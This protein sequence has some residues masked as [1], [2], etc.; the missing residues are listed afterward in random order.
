MRIRDII[1]KQQGIHGLE[2]VT[3]LA[4][5]LAMNKEQLFINLDRQIDET[6]NMRIHQFIS[7][8]QQGKPLAY[9]TGTKEFFSEEFCVDERVLI[10]RPET[11]LLVEEAIK[12]LAKIPKADSIIDMGTGSGAVGLTV[13]RIT[14]KRVLCVDESTGAL[15]VAKSNARKLGVL[16]T[17]AF[18]CS[19]LFRAI[20]RK[21]IFD[22]VL[23]N[24]PYVSDDEW[25]VLMDDV[26]KYEPRKA[27][28]GG[29][30]GATIYRRLIDDLPHCLKDD[31]YVLCEVGGEG[32]AEQ[33]TEM[34]DRVGL[35]VIVKKDF[36][37]KERVLIGSWTN[38][39]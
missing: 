25:D 5:A 39:S 6:S 17:V 22:V 34:L 28:Y 37:Y 12:V 11:E 20:K 4:H 31:G 24:L 7:E 21:K 16:D 32:R 18:L 19:D 30:D 33:V 1:S 26:R 35:H 3:I 9:I 13:A 23:A 29:K 2:T 38:L 27:L 36:S 10:P 8:R 15:A 14:K